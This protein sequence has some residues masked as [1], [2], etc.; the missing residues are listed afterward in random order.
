MRR[1]LPSCWARSEWCSATSAPARCTRCRPSSPSTGRACVR[2]AGDVYG[3]ISM[4][5]WSI[6]LIVSVKYVTFMLR[7]DNDGEGGVMALAAL[8][9]RLLGRVRGG[10]PGD[11]ARHHGRLPVLRRQRDHAGDLGAVGGRGDQGGLAEPA[12]VV[13]AGRGILAVLFVVQRWGTHRVGRLFGPVMVLWFAR[14]VRRECGVPRTRASS[15]GCLRAMPLCSSPTA[16]TSRSSP[17]AQWFSPSRARK[18]CMPT[19]AT[20]AGRRS[21]SRGFCIVF[22][23]L[24]LN[25]LAQGALILRDR[26]ARANPFFLL[27]P[28]WARSRW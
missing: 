14:W 12:R 26:G 1:A 7:A 20:S 2:R 28:H 24:T 21:A 27:V 5:F 16:P 10:G 13:R 18:P 3:I 6:T 17:W 15:G 19:S 25:Y 9:R 22:P 11:G 4:V 8:V 23:A